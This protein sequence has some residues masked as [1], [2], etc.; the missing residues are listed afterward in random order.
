MNRRLLT[1]SA[2]VALLIA[3]SL[4]MAAEAK[5]PTGHTFARVDTSAF[6]K[7]DP[8]LVKQML[9]GGTRSV[10]VIVQL[11]GTPVAGETAAAKTLGKTLSLTDKAS[12]RTRIKANQDALKPGISRAGGRVLRQ[13]QDAINGLRVQVAVKDLPKLAALS[14]VT[15]V[16]AI[17][18]VS[19]TNSVS[20]PYTGTPA[21][22]GD[23]GFTG[24]GVKIA[25][26]DT[27]IDYTHADFGGAGAAAFAANDPTII[28][29]GTFPTAKVVGGWDLVGDAYNADDP[30][31]V[32]APDPD[33]IDCIT[34]QHGTHVAGTAAGEGVNADGSTYTGPYDSSIDFSSFKVGP[35]VAPQASLY[36]FRVFGCEG[37]TDVVVDAINMAVMA[38]VDVI[39]MSLGSDFGGADTPDA[40]AAD[41]ASLAGISVVISAGN[42]GPNPYIVGSPGTS[43]RAITVG[44]M[45]ARPTLL[46]GTIVDLPGSND[47][48]GWNMYK[49][50]LPVSGTLHALTADGALVTGCTADDFSSV[51][52]G[53]VV[54]ISR[55]VCAFSDK[56]AFAQ[57]AG[58]AAVILVNNVPGVAINPVDDPASTIAV[59]SLDPADGPA[60]IAADGQ[61]VTLHVG[62]VP[63]VT[64]RHSAEF[65]SSGPRIGDNAMK[66]DV[67][68]PGVAVVS[69]LVGSG[70]GSLD[71]SGTSMASPYTAGVVA[72]VTQAHPSWTPAQVKAAISNTA[73]AS[74]LIDDYD[75]LIAGSGVVQP[76]LAVDTVGLATLPGGVS[77]LAY[78]YEAHSRSWS[79]TKRITLTNT[80]KHRITYDLSSSFVGGSQ[81]ARVDIWPR[82]VT[83]EP[84]R[85]AVV[86]VRISL[87]AAALAALPAQDAFA[88][89]SAINTIRGAIVATPR[90]SRA[91]VYP[92]R[93]PFLLV[94]RGT[95]NVAPKGSA[96]PFSVNDGIATSS[97]RLKNDQGHD[98]NAD[99]YAWGEKDTREGYPLTDIRATGVQSLPGAA[100]GLA[101][102]D[103]LMVFAVNTWGRWSSPAQL[104]VEVE[105][106]TNKDGTT[107]FYLV[108][109]DGGLMLSGVPNGQPLSFLF[110]ADFNLVDLWPVSAP[111]NGSNYL[112]LA[113][114]SSLGL[115]GDAGSFDYD[116]YV[117]PVFQD[118][119]SDSASG[120]GHF[121][122][123]HPA[124][125]QGD[126]IGLSKGQS[127]TL[128]LS[129]DIAAY[130]AN[131]ALGWLIATSDDA[132]GAPQ[133]DLVP[134]G[135]P[136]KH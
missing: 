116:T 98:G 120:Q 24:A 83:V 117:Y 36:S 70:D 93:V 79:E 65:T 124:V 7:I 25:I 136:S 115:T 101:D 61:A 112:L 50:P 110:D 80:G 106:D 67:S 134:I 33:P 22:W 1:T 123:F 85:R 118:V 90:K 74:A 122:P 4:P 48:G 35:G 82:K 127:A 95:S 111:V 41:N 45:N 46:N 29:P 12:F 119:P 126:F 75:P 84:G 14:G 81:G 99:V 78:G 53:E 113:A 77:S 37:T 129:I 107:D 17:P 40:I 92:L 19:R 39:N 71:L 109:Y 114:A 26:L 86:D 21:A 3:M 8:K 131:P 73:S 9:G 10:N 42:A 76:R 5:S 133:A 100:G 89:G 103:R 11:A 97:I 87:S 135:R 13:Y 94:P 52:P 128:G 68:A 63:D 15:A 105:I 69:A 31:S 108:G 51:T 44:A 96:R 54:A 23:T 59:I 58:A 2:A 66:P 32:P 121:D 57:A 38:N 125:S 28:E 62:D 64:Y 27:G 34:G 60:V 20:V 132:N 47:L 18:K 102:D 55:G 88:D 91:G 30:T 72:L 6:A 49:S 104:D 16:R 43:S 56:R 130:K